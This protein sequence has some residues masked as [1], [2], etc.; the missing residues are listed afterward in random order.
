MNLDDVVLVPN[1]PSEGRFTLCAIVGQYQFDLSSDPRAVGDFRHALPVKVLTPWEGVSNASKLVTAGLQRTM[2][3]RSRMWSLDTH[4]EAI[5]SIIQT[6]NSLEGKDLLLGIEPEERADP[7]L[8]KVFEEP[9]EMP[10]APIVKDLRNAFSNEAGC[11]YDLFL[12][13]NSADHGVV[14]GIAQRLRDAGLEPFV[15]RWYLT[16]GAPWRTKL[17]EIL[18]ASKAVAI[19]VGQGQMGSWQQRELDAALDLQSKNP[20]FPV[21]PVLLP[22]SEAP[23]GFLGQP[24]WVFKGSLSIRQSQF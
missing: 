23:L 1:M 2:K 14:E 3:A 10:L 21:L 20:D 7:I 12:S 24:M 16:P 19:C 8:G 17:E 4:A 18:T 6:A 15:D 9:S 11:N 13:Y 5:E 22:G